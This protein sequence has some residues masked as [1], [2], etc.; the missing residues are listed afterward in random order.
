MADSLL[1]VNGTATVNSTSPAALGAMRSAQQVQQ[2]MMERLL[3]SIAQSGQLA[4]PPSRVD[5]VEISQEAQQRL[6]AES[7]GAC[8]TC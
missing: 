7:G 5:R 4:S 1:S 8:S 6:A 2:A 3:A